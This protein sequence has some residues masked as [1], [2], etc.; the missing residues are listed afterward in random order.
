M[1]K[2]KN[3]KVKIN[4]ITFDSKKE[5]QRW[6]SLSF[7]LKAGLITD[8][9]RQVN[10]E[11]IPTIKHENKILSKI[12]YRAD[13]TYKKDGVLIVEDSKG[14][15]TPEFKIKLRLFLLKYPEYTF[16]IT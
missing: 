7:M 8:L 2:Y 11:L 9:E 14:F 10:F 12:S 4:G 15:E 1:N 16:K 6:C 13:F 5:Y 3:I